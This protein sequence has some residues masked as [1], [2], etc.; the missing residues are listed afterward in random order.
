MRRVNI[1]KTQ[2]SGLGHSDGKADRIHCS[3]GRARWGWDV[4]T[5][6]KMLFPEAPWRACRRPTHS[7]RI[8]PNDLTNQHMQSKIN[9]TNHNES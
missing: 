4:G 3:R 2:V 1:L 9:T 5:P 7:D 6:G 8:D